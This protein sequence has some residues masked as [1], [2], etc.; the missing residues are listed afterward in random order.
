MCNLP[1]GPGRVARL[2]GETGNLRYAIKAL[3]L[4]RHAVN[5][6]LHAMKRAAGLR[7][8][9]NVWINTTTGE[10]RAQGTGELIGNLLP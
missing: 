8:A 3:G 10:V 7:G 2:V 9:D 1:I 6:E 5:R 4:N